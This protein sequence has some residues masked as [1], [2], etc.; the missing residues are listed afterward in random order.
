MKNNMDLGLPKMNYDFGFDQ[1]KKEAN[2][3]LLKMLKTRYIQGK[4][5]TEQYHEMK[6]TL[7]GGGDLTEVGKSIKKFYNSLYSV[8]AAIGKK[9]SKNKTIS[10]SKTECLED[11]IRCK[12]IEKEGMD[13]FK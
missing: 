6:Q 1:K 13:Y 7:Y 9:T 4:I 2:D 11:N 5:T 3:V 12:T 8:G 10:D